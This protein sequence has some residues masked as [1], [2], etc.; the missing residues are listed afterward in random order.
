MTDFKPGLY[1][2]EGSQS[3]LFLVKEKT[4]ITVNTTETEPVLGRYSSTWHR[5]FNTRLDNKYLEA[6]LTQKLQNI[7]KEDKIM[8]D[9]EKFKLLFYLSGKTE[10]FELRTNHRKEKVLVSDKE[11]I[12]VSSISRYEI[13]GSYKETTWIEVNIYGEKRELELDTLYALKAFKEVF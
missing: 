11:A 9:K 2:R 12:K 7:V 13:L 1:T 6:E 5:D 3:M 4:G 10:I 8:T